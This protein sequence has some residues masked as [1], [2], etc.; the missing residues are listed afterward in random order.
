MVHVLKAM[1]DELYS[2]SLASE[3]PVFVCVYMHVCACVSPS[4]LSQGVREVF[5]IYS[6]KQ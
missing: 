1:L 2:D 3:C 5:T 6:V 4:L